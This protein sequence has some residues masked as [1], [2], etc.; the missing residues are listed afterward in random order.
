MK[1]DTTQEYR[2]LAVLRAAEKPI[3][4]HEIQARIWSVFRRRDSETAISARIRELRR[5]LELSGQTI[6]CHKESV[7][8][9]TYTII[10]VMKGEA[11]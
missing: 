3:A 5:S 11:A 6:H 9:F 8:C 10:D 2:V 4:L 7:G 1:D